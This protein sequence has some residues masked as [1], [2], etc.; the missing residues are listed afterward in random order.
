MLILISKAKSFQFPSYS[1]LPLVYFLLNGTNDVILK[2]QRAII[3]LSRKD[4][5]KTAWNYLCLVLENVDTDD[6]VLSHFTQFR[7]NARNV[8]YQ[9]DLEKLIGKIYTFISKGRDYPYKTFIVQLWL[10][11]LNNNLLL[12]IFG[13]S[14]LHKFLRTT[15]N[16]NFFWI[17]LS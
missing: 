6:E 15:N 5:I 4:F 3:K 16:N 13:N 1:A 17:R 12:Y 11:H 9:S 2:C 10:L 8:T 14:Q 7:L